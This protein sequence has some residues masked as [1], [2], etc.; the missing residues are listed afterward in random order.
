MLLRRSRAAEPESLLLNG[1][2][3]SC[4]HL[5]EVFELPMQGDEV[6]PRYLV[7]ACANP[8]PRNAS[9]SA[10]SEQVCGLRRPLRNSRQ[11]KPWPLA[12][13]PVEAV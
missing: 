3:R 5:R 12:P 7:M 8:K 6:H 11:K 1:S 10:S 4:Q 2:F 13:Q 9:Y